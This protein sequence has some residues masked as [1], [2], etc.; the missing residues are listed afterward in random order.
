MMTAK[1]WDSATD[2]LI[3]LTESGRIRWEPAHQMPSASDHGNAS[4][5]V[6]PAYVATV[7]EKRV[8]VY[9]YRYRLYTDADEWH[10]STE[11]AVGF[12]DNNDQME[13]EWPSPRRR[14]A[15]LD[16]IR[17]QQSGAEQF[18]DRLLT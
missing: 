3:E 8:A 6:G 2:K 4:E 10:W 5:L 11:I 12:V 18:L 17:Y 9:E 13:W 7:E 14:S 16:A 15:L 1:S